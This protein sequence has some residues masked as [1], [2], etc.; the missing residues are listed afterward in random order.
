[1]PNAIA[2][3]PFN[4][5]S[6]KELKL[7]LGRTAWDEQELLEILEEVPLD[8][9]YYHTHGHFLRHKYI[10]RPYHNDFA[11]WVDY[12]VRDRVLGERLGLLDPLDFTD[13]EA[14][15]GEIIQIIDDHLSRL[16]Q[17][18]RVIFGEPFYFMRSRIV[19][20][21]IGRSARTLLEFRDNLA[22]VDA[23]TIYFHF[24]DSRIRLG[25]RRGDFATW[26][27]DELGETE[28]S[29]KIAAINPYFLS[30]EGVRAKILALCDEALAGRGAP[31]TTH[32]I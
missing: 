4:F 14:L 15:R 23:G 2:A 16:Q 12:E 22:V 25:R 5:V 10:V 26:L 19:E 6:C 8:C 17:V 3:N 24:I 13:L 1:M 29:D 31:L 11:A 32:G 27:A 28:L 18:P 30:M 7:M 21:P 20:A 9:I